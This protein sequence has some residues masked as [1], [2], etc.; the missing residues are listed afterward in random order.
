MNAGP[1]KRNCLRCSGS[2]RELVPLWM[3]EGA[4]GTCQ[5]CGGTGRVECKHEST[6]FDPKAWPTGESLEIC[7]DCGMSRTH[8]E[9][10]ESPWMMVEDI[11]A[12]RAEIEGFL[13]TH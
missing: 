6:R 10:G 11:E 12:A 13:S 7:N 3:G 8:W 1:G 5:N 9:Q 4:D 2:G